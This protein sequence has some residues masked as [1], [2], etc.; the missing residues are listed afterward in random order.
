M[1]KVL[2]FGTFDGLHIG[3]LSFLEQARR[4]GDRLIVVVARDMN[5]KRS[6]GRRPLNDEKK[7]VASLKK[8]ADRVILGERKVT[9]KLIKKISPDVICI[10]YDQ[11]PSISRARKILRR[12][13]MGRVSL[14]KMKPY[15]PS[16]YKS[17]RLNELR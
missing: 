7:R 2:V 9:Y 1:K 14:K 5:V 8:F 10:G 17:S 6:K 11:N 16:V 3:H 15:R 13:G 12:I 4:H